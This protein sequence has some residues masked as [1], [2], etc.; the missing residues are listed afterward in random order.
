MTMVFQDNSCCHLMQAPTHPAI[1][2]MPQPTYAFLAMQPGTLPAAQTVPGDQPF[3]YLHHL[4]LALAAQGCQV[5]LLTRRDS[6]HQP[7]VVRYAPGYR[8]IYLT[9]GPTQPIPYDQILAYLPAFVD[10]W[11][12]FQQRSRQHYTLIQ[13]SDWLSGW[14]GMQLRTRLQVPLVHSSTA[15]SALQYLWQE[16]TQVTSIRQSVERSCLAQADRV[17]D[18]ST[19]DHKSVQP[20]CTRQPIQTIPRGVDPQLLGFRSQGSARQ[21]LGLANSD[22]MILYVGHFGILQGVDT[23]IE[24]CAQLS[25]PFHLYLVDQ[26]DPEPSDREEQQFI[27]DLVKHLHLTNQ[28][29]FVGNIPRSHL[30]AYYAAAD[31]CIVPNDHG[32]AGAVALAAMATGTPVIASDVG[33]F[34]QVVKPGKTGLLVPPFDPVAL[35][36]A[37]ADVLQHPIRW[38]T[39]GLAGQQWV[40]THYSYAAIATKMHALYESVMQDE[41]LPTVQSQ[42]LFCSA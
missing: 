29:S 18:A 16:T 22:R 19:L 27:Q 5:D 24:A 15:I 38:Q 25:Q 12:A 8:L 40:E 36:T 32:H 13:T 10:A 33:E 28:V 26:D 41:Q 7:R 14:V 21:Q 17:V 11:L 3:F 2:P 23:L 9:A 35:S 4:A 1:A 30:S 39:Y 37:I 20:T 31:V 6:P 34:R 42:A